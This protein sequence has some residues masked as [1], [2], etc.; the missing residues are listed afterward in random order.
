MGEPVVVEAELSGGKLTVAMDVPCRK[1][2]TFR[3][4]MVHPPPL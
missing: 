1:L 3:I 4:V 2:A